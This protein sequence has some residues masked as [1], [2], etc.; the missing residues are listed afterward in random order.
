MKLNKSRGGGGEKRGEFN[1]RRE[2]TGHTIPMRQVS[3]I[4]KMAKGSDIEED[5]LETEVRKKRE[6]IVRP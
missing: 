4:S 6:I 3:F 1:P 2:S 5:E